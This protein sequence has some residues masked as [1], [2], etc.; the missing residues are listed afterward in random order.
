LDKINGGEITVLGEVVRHNEVIKVGKK[1]G[2][3][4]QETALINQFTIKETLLYFG[5]VFGVEKKVLNERYRFLKEL[6]ELPEDDKIV[7]N[8]SGGQKRRVSLGTAL[9]HN[10]FLLIL[11]E[12]TVGLDPVKCLTKDL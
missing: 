8:C 1:I 3:V 9:I 10:P 5:N 6:L 2:Y 12:P 7:G 11:D 4:P